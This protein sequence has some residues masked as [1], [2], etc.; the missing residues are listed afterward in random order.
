MSLLYDAR[1][2]QNGGAIDVNGRCY[3]C[4]YD[5]AGDDPHAPDCPWRSMPQIMATLEAA[6]R[7]IAE[8]PPKTDAPKCS[9][10]GAW[11]K[12]ELHAGDCAWWALVRVMVG[13]SR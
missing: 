3:F 1:R 8:G 6:E 9:Y 5:L 12:D 10:C 4:G 13:E 2:I 11:F 7:L